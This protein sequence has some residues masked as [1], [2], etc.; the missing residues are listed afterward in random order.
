MAREP[1]RRI[2]ERAFCYGEVGFVRFFRFTRF[3]SFSPVRGKKVSSASAYGNRVVSENR[4]DRPGSGRFRFRC[5]A[6]AVLFIFHGNK[7]QIAAGGHRSRLRYTHRSY[8]QAGPRGFKSNIRRRNDVV[9]IVESLKGGNPRHVKTRQ[10]FHD[11]V[12]A[13]IFQ[14]RVRF[15]IARSRA[16]IHL[17][18]NEPLIIFKGGDKNLLSALFF[19]FRAFEFQR[20]C[21]VAVPQ[22]VAGRKIVG[23]S[24][25]RKRDMH[26]R[27]GRNHPAERRNSRK[28]FVV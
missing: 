9:R 22:R 3:Q 6:Y 12:V 17:P 16:G 7:R 10:R 25:A 23:N 2:F 15:K 20:K 27:F 28:F 4:F 19:V 5:P 26:L 13:A 24:V 18:R 21:R 8:A 14:F 11:Y 1:R